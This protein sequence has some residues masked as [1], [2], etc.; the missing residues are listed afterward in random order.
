MA[1]AG[2]TSLVE[3]RDG[4][5]ET[6]LKVSVVKVGHTVTSRDDVTI[7]NFAL[8]DSTGAVLGNCSDKTKFEVIKEGRTLH[9]RNYS[10]KNGRLKIGTKTRMVRGPLIVVPEE[11]LQRG[12]DLL[13]PPSPQKKITEALI[14]K[15]G[16]ILTI[17]G[18]IVKVCSS[19]VAS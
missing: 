5:T 13:C 4:P 2:V 19:V 1:A 10:L 17:T 7:L 3:L 18:Q 6:L 9:L 14:A 8:A 11:M 12:R 16:D 15:K